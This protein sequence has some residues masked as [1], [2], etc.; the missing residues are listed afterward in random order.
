MSVSLPQP[1]GSAKIYAT[2]SPNQSQEKTWISKKM[3]VIFVR[4]GFFAHCSAGY[5]RER[6]EVSKQ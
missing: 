5:V 4:F 1:S 3:Y 2:E 6:K